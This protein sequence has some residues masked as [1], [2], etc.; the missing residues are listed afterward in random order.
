MEDGRHYKTII[1]GDYSDDVE[2]NY[3]SH[4]LTI[5]VNRYYKNEEIRQSRLEENT[6][7]IRLI[8]VSNKPNCFKSQELSKSMEV[9]ST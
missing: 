2:I 7:K 5:Q 9:G 1:G 8:G 6:I 3:S 4:N